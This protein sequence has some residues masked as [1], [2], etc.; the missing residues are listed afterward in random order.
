MDENGTALRVQAALSA[1]TLDV[2]EAKL[3]AEKAL[4]NHNI[5]FGGGIQLFRKRYANEFKLK[6]RPESKQVKDWSVV[7]DALWPTV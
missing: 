3:L 4:M 7:V 2:S 5:L 6:L 1:Y